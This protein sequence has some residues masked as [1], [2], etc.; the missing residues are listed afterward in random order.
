MRRERWHKFKRSRMQPQER[1][2]DQPINDV[3]VQDS[4]R[5]RAEYAERVWEIV[6][7]LPEHPAFY[8]LRV[9]DKIVGGIGLPSVSTETPAALLSR[10]RRICAGVLVGKHR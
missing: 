10:N 1:L 8:S 7:A 6:K 9:A 4:V 2:V 5:L 3:V